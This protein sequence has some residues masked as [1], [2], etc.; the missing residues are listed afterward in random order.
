MDVNVTDPRLYGGDPYPVYAW[1][2]EHAA[3]YTELK[4][5][6]KAVGLPEIVVSDSGHAAG[7][8]MRDYEGFASAD[9]P[10]NALLVECGQHWE[11]PA[12]PLA[13]QTAL[14]FLLVHDMVDA[15]WA[16]EGLE[17]IE[18]PEQRF[19]EVSGPVTI[20][21]QDFRFVEDYRGLEV[22]PEAGSIIAYDGDTPV[23]TPYEDCVLIMPSRRLNQ[24]A[25]AVRL[26]RYVEV[27]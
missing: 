15:D 27:D 10:K 12:G 23:K 8:R 4:A 25:S 3:G 24:G 2:R 26:G 19:I 7:R 22:I 21:T 20:E 1:L 6:G 18:L 9:S 13:I 5:H 11:A 16:T 17:G 14:R